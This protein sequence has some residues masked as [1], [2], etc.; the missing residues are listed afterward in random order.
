[1]NSDGAEMGITAGRALDAVLGGKTEP[2]EESVQTR[3]EV[4]QRIEAAPLPGDG[5]PPWELAEEMNAYSLATDSLAHAFLVLAE[6]RPELLEHDGRFPDDFEI[7]ELRGRPTG[8]PTGAIWEA[9]KE[10]WPGA[11]EWIGGATGFMVGFAFNQVRWLM[12]K[13]PAP[14]PAIVTV[15]VP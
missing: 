13:P 7:E 1:M 3:E 6:E 5:E 8:D 2:E 10:R 11:D 4:R 15:D 9:M 12:E 14:N